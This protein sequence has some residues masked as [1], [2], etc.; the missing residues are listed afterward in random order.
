MSPQ[1]IRA[2]TQKSLESLHWIRSLEG[3]SKHFRTFIISRT[4]FSVAALRQVTRA[5]DLLDAAHVRLLDAEVDVLLAA[6]DKVVCR[7][8]LLAVQESRDRESVEAAYCLRT[9]CSTMD[10]A[11]S[12][13]VS[14]AS[15]PDTHEAE[16]VLILTELRS[17]VEKMRAAAAFEAAK[18]RIASPHLTSGRSG[19]CPSV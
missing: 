10:A 5:L 7:T 6:C 14:R 4:P 3:H 13:E 1:T 17:H 19:L 15:I 16:A 9:F 12:P 2:I 11:C 18:D 8:K